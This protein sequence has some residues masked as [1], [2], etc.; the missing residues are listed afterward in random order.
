MHRHQDSITSPSI[1]QRVFNSLLLTTIVFLSACS[2]LPQMESKEDQALRK[3]LSSNHQQDLE[4]YPMARTYRGSRKDYDQ[5][6]NLSEDFARKSYEINQQRLT[7]L[8]A[9]DRQQLTPQ[10]QLSAT[11]YQQL[12]ERAQQ[13]YT[14]RHHNY[15]MQQMSGWHTGIPSFLINMHKISSV[16]DAEDY[17][18]RLYGIRP[19]VE[20]I[21][22]QLEIRQQKGIFPP[23]WAYPQMIEASENV[24][25]GLPFDNG[26]QI[27]SLLQ[28]FR[29]KLAALGIPH[30]LQTQLTADA[31][32]ALLNAVKPA[33]VDLIQSLQQQMNIADNRDGVW[34]LPDGERYYDLL[35]QHYTTT[36]LSADEI[37]QIGLREVQRIHGE[38]LDILAAV[39]FKGDL[40][41]FF[42]FMRTDQQF[43]FADTAKGRDQYLNKT[44]QVIKQMEARLPD[45]F[46]ILPKAELTVK[47]VEAFRERSAAKAFYDAP[48]SDG[49]RPGIYYVNLYDMSAMPSYQLEALAYHEALPGHHLQLAI[50]KELENVPEFRKDASFTAYIEG[51]GLYAE[52]LAKEMQA[53]SN[54]YSDFGR[55]TMDLWRA[56]RLVVDTGIH[57]KRWTREQ[58]IDYLQTNTPNSEVDS[59]KAIE[60]YSV[61]PGQATAY[62]IGKLKILELRNEAQAELGEAFDI[63]AFHDEVLKNGPLPLSVLEDLIHH[64][65]KQQQQ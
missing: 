26:P 35:L 46:G 41:D 6:N 28:D 33:Y 3:F 55:L 9:F 23:H 8:A 61:Y 22:T 7:Q 56:C 18:S 48:A 15:I 54:P 44:R 32:A 50:T 60:R 49:S 45:W 52:H 17:I 53:Y 16:Q 38:M 37:H 27:S 47:P 58:A 40:Q 20:Q 34:K 65:V 63:R 30:T 36:E 4:R 5:W 39:D 1:A 42:Q 43:Y 25:S 29:S 10:N 31:E 62:M 12:L 57:A 59:T 51:W 19:L 24:I 21:I 2:Q 64:W 13:F 11:L 14:F